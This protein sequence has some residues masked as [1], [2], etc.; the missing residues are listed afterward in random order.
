L[1]FSWF[2]PKPSILRKEK[3]SYPNNIPVEGDVRIVTSKNTQIQMFAGKRKADLAATKL[4]SVQKRQSGHIQIEY[5]QPIQRNSTESLRS[6]STASSAQ[7]SNRVFPFSIREPKHTRDVTVIVVLLEMMLCSCCID[8]LHDGSSEN[9]QVQ[10][11]AEHDERRQPPPLQ[12]LVLSSDRVKEDKAQQS[13]V[14]NITKT[15][16]K[17]MGMKVDFGERHMLKVVLIR[18]GLVTSW[19]EEHPN[20]IVAEGDFLV[21]VNDKKG[22]AKEMLEEIARSNVLDI[23]IQKK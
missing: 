17:K 5:E 1:V 18:E 19:N 15:K 20:M 9:V 6:A 7:V 10:L 12:G 4:N 23:V 3:K 21:A 13:F 11:A 16:E 2:I 8:D 14:V 22:S